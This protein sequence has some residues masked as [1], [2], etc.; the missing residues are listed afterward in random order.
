MTGAARRIQHAGITTDHPQALP[1]LHHTGRVRALHQP[2]VQ[3]VQRRDMDFGPGLGQRPI[4]NAMNQAGAATEV[5]KKR[6]QLALNG[7]PTKAHQDAQQ[8]WQG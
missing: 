6:V 2:L 1:A 8:P 5:G 4:T 7:T 3:V